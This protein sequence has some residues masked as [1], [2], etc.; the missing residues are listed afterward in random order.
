M[1]ELL[2]QSEVEQYNEM[3]TG[4]VTAMSKEEIE[5]KMLDVTKEIAHIKLFIKTDRE[6]IRTLLDRVEENVF[7]YEQYAGTL[8]ALAV[9]YYDAPEAPND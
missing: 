6:Q 2:S 9:A 1:D 3:T 5:S 8:K 4:G 7:R